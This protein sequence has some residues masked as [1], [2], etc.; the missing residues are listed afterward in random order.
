MWAS[1]HPFSRAGSS[2]RAGQ[3]GQLE[4]VGDCVTGRRPDPY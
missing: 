2:S 1:G 4:G 3:A